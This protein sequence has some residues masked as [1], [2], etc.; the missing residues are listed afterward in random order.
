MRNIKDK[1]K[2]T[3]QVFISIF[4]ALEV[5]T[6]PNPYKTHL[7]I[8]LFAYI[9]LKHGIVEKIEKLIDKV[10]KWTKI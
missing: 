6:P 4:L 3:L 9:T 8:L 5:S 1:I 10:I 2:I 7:I